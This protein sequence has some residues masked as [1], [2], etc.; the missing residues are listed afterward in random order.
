[1]MRAK[2]TAATSHMCGRMEANCGL[3]VQIGAN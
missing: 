3:S 1:M 2:N